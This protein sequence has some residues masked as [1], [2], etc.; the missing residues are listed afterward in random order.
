MAEG[1]TIGWTAN[2]A[3]REAL[4]HYT[5]WEAPNP[6]SGLSGWSFQL[7]GNRTV[8]RHS[9]KDGGGGRRKEGGIWGV[10]QNLSLSTLNIHP[11]WALHPQNDIHATLVLFK[12]LS[13]GTGRSN[14]SQRFFFSLFG[15][16][17]IQGEKRETDWEWF[18]EKEKE[19]F[20]KFS[21]D[22]APNMN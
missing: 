10:V 3:E 22:L 7:W 6:L 9:E 4:K 19:N 18:R 20:F 11:A 2:S 1:V 21:K 14:D 15:I 13:A 17:L 5:G 8:S 12:T 16:K